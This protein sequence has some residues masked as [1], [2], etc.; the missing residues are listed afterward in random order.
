MKATASISKEDQERLRAALNAEDFDDVQLTAFNKKK[1]SFN[2][3]YSIVFHDSIKALSRMNLRPNAY[4][5]VLYMFSIL[6][7]GNIIINFSQKQIAADMGLQQSNVSRA[8]KELF[9]K[10]VLI[11]DSQNGHVYFNSNIATIGIPKNFNKQTMDNLQRSQIETEDFK[12]SL[13]LTKSVKTKKLQSKDENF[14]DEENQ[15]NLN[16]LN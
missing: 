3:A 4:K 14:T 8:F 10:K 6:Q 2:A 5:I 13:N 7:M 1:T 11:K 16:F 12:R 15:E 9:E